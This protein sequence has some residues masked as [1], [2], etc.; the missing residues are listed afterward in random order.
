[1][2]SLS[3]IAEKSGFEII[4]KGTYFIKPFTNIQ[5]EQMIDA[6]IIGENI[7]RGLEKMIKYMPDLGAE[8]Y[9][10]VKREK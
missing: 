10:N 1:M 9:I 5:F 4:D 8:M 2:K 6:K 3:E 7:F